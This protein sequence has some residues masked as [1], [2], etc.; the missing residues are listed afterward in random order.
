MAKSDW[1]LVGKQTKKG[2]SKNAAKSVA[3]DA[4]PVAKVEP[5][6]VISNGKA[7]ESQVRSYLTLD[8]CSLIPNQ[9]FRFFL[10]SS[11]AR[12]S[13]EKMTFVG[14]CSIYINVAN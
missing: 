10:H 7:K 4:K 2:A 8:L 6:K 14:R 11:T 3:K 5:A 1:E 13:T 9:F 12:G